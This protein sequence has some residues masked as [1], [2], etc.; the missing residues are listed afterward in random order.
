MIY[1]IVNFLMLV[2]GGY[3]EMLGLYFFFILYQMIIEKFEGFRYFF[4]FYFVV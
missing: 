1:Y 4:V 2:Y 3:I